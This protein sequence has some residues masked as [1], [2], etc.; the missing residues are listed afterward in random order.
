MRRF[1]N[2]DDTNHG[3]SFM[4]LK[5]LVGSHSKSE[6]DSEYTAIIAYSGKISWT[7]EFSRAD[8]Y[9]VRCSRHEFTC[10][11]MTSSGTKKIV[12][13]TGARFN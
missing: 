5:E 11:E 9:R 4:S 12:C 8:S 13:Y 3:V 2:T 10:P 6:N 1:W 7:F